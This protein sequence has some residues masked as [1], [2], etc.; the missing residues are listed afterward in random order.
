MSA[1]SAV[2]PLA[3]GIRESGA[4]VVD[5][6]V[7]PGAA[8]ANEGVVA[9]GV[10]GSVALCA[11]AGVVL[12]ESSVVVAGVVRSAWV[13]LGEV[14]AG[15]ADEVVVAVS[16]AGL[17]V[18]V[19]GMLEA[20]GVAAA[21]VLVG[22]GGLIVDEG[23]GVAAGAAVDPGEEA[24]VVGAA[25]VTAG[26]GAAE[27]I[28]VMAGM[29]VAGA[30]VVAEEVVV[31]AAAVVAEGV[32]VAGAA[33]V[34]VTVRPTAPAGCCAATAAMRCAAVVHR[35]NMSGRSASSTPNSYRILAHMVPTGSPLKSAG[36]SFAQ[37]IPMTSR[38]QSDMDARVRSPPSSADP[39]CRA[40]LLTRSRN[41]ENASSR[42]SSCWSCLR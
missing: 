20:R 9:M 14:V 15:G 31:A 42:G 33:V 22:G 18:V 6:S 7:T 2:T 36:S 25:V 19:A 13:V 23:G 24:V 27:G 37:I 21:G 4:L 26:I 29:V 41:Q 34:T 40:Q 11:A 39:S 3:S 38:C 28:V 35:L 30:A 1:S 5:T 17:S 16:S 8:E 12:P 32:V 10:V